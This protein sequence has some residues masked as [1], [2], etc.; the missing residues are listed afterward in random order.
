MD[1]KFPHTPHLAWLGTNPP[2]ADKVLT[3]RERQQFL[4]RPVIVEE[5]LDGANIG[6]S[7]DATL[8]TIVQNRGVVL[9]R[10]SHPQFQ[11][12]WPWLAEHQMRLAD[13]MRDRL[14]LFGEWCFAVHSVRYIHLPDY[15]LAFDV[16]DRNERKFWSANRR[17]EWALSLGIVTV[18]RVSEGRFSLED[19]K[20]RLQSST[21]QF[22]SALIEGL[23]LR[24]DEGGWLRNRAKLVRPEF[25]EAIDEH[26]TSHAL[27]RNLV[28]GAK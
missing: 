1:F 27:E 23:Y 12:L 26:W 14:I 22:G 11:A 5:K 10:G 7:F 28:I 16:Y 17:D 3:V 24:Q 15:F 4:S 2:R 6:I 21:S 20:R 18:P 13:E 8:S 9:G 25:T 19:L